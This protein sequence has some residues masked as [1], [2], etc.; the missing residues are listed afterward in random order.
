MGPIIRSLIHLQNVEQNLRVNQTL[1]ENSQQSVKRLVHAVVQLQSSLSAKHEEIKLTRLQN[2]K[3]EL[4]LKVEDEELSRLRVQLN[5]A[6]TNRDYS[7]ILTKINTD[8][9]D[10]SRLEDRI[11]TLMGQVEND[12]AVCKEIETEIQDTEKKLGVLKIANENKE[13]KFRHDIQNLQNQQ[14]EAFTQIPEQTRMSFV[15]LADR[16]DGEVLAQIIQKR[17]GR[18]TEHSCGGCFMSIPLE[19]ANTLMTK[20]EVIPCPS[21]GRIIVLELTEPQPST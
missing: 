8:K 6:K 16:Y 7:A 2:S 3:Y 11:L 10:K 1:L 9:V 15:K 5:T 21:C 4:D 18:R 12:Q 17:M 13:T 19:L 14:Q 20:D